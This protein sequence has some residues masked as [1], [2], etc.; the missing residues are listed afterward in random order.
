[1]RVSYSLLMLLDQYG[2][3]TAAIMTRAWGEQVG[4]VWETNSLQVHYKPLHDCF[5][6]HINTE[7][8][9]GRR[10]VA[11]ARW[12]RIN[13]ASIV[14]DIIRQALTVPQQPHDLVRSL[15]QEALSASDK[16]ISND[17][18]QPEIQDEEGAP[19]FI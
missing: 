11:P 14:G 4:I 9:M 16:D 18:T 3:K 5:V 7:G 13:W 15:L 1:M 12:A 6:M 17:N 2:D 19:L 10:I 8:V